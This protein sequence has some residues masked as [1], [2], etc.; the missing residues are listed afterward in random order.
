MMQTIR[1]RAQGIVI[2]I[3]V[4]L[5]IVTFATFGL[6]SYL[7]GT[8]SV[9]AA[10]VN[11][12]AIS[13]SA[14]L[15]AYQQEQTR[16]QSKLGKNYRPD[17]I[18]APALKRQVLEQMIQRTLLLQLIKDA[19]FRVAPQVV[20]EQIRVM[21]AFQNN[22]KFSKR[23]YVQVLR[24]QGMNE[25]NFEQDMTNDIMI[26]DL[27]NGVSQSAFVTKPELA[28]YEGLLRQ[29]RDV[30]ILSIPE[31]G[32]LASAKVN[33]ADIKAYYDKHRKDFVTPEQVSVRYIKLSQAA[34]ANRIKV[35]DAA[36][37]QYY[38]DHIKQFVTHPEERRASHILI[39]VDKQTT[40]AAAL[41][42]IEKLRKKIA[43]GASFYAMAR[44]YSQD[45]FSAKKGGDL[46]YLTRGVMP[47]TFDKKLFQLKKGQIS[48]P[49]LTRFGYHL[50]Q[51]EAIKP[52]EI[53][54]FD[55]VKG[56]IRHDVQ[57]Q[58]ASMQFYKEADQLT[59]L[60]YEYPDSLDFVAK[61]L[62]LKEKKT[63]L[64]GRQGARKGLAAN[65]KV[66]AAAFSDEV[67]NQ[68]LNSDALEVGPNTYVVVRLAN[69]K[70]AR[71]QPLAVVSGEI[72]VQ[73]RQQWARHAARV[74]ADKALQAMERGKSPK[75]IAA[76]YK[77]ARWLQI[78]FI[79]RSPG[80]D[81]KNAKPIGGVLR[82]MAFRMPKPVMQKR[83]DAAAVPSRKAVSL[84][85][86]SAAV[87]VVSGVQEGSAGVVIQAKR[88]RAELAGVLGKTGINALLQGARVRADVSINQKMLNSSGQ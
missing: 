38:T 34:I 53:S 47:P 44:K 40:A 24:N 73:L 58:K 67:L 10:N 32:F 2:W 17:M 65:P 83:A 25:Q 55:Q 29:Q 88:L 3:I 68:G 72:E 28:T 54:S 20:G 9:N 5:I 60:S 45:T 77:G 22:G 81:G 64:F 62:G 33:A 59:N 1:D 74:A 19:G 66:V 36:L 69:H 13:E 78:G 14:F 23:R 11:G 7:S 8:S 15:H 57:L 21:S 63:A 31:A 6:E 84:P 51:L 41:K 87:L 76:I 79:G 61:Q 43:A 39:K 86:G 35:S 18:N 52:A 4:G 82:E 56:R 48:K 49:V 37:H 16:L 46:G 27:I 85:D 30:G 12:T 26:R 80:L 71:P 75:Q 50:I 70:R 42:E